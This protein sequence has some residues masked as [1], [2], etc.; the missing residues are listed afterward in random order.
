[1]LLTAAFVVTG[2]MPLHLPRPF[3]PPAESAYG[4]PLAEAHLDAC[5]RAGIALSAVGAGAVPGQWQFQ[6]GPASPLELG[7]MASQL[8]ISPLPSLNSQARVSLIAWPLLSPFCRSR[9]RGG[10]STG[11]ARTLA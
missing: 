4:R 1:M 7:D 10:C 5:V 2:D 9:W 8:A 11:S 3:L 6:M